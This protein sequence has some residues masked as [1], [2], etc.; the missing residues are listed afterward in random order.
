MESSI[1]QIEEASGPVD[2]PRGTVDCELHRVVGN[3]FKEKIEGFLDGG[4]PLA[5]IMLEARQFVFDR[6]C[7]VLWE[8]MAECGLTAENMHVNMCDPWLAERIRD[9]ILFE[10]GIHEALTIFRLYA[11]KDGGGFDVDWFLKEEKRFEM[12]I[13]AYFNVG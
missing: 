8:H 6:V 9:R 11:K 13:D 7:S 1:N 3:K 12:Q 5:E 4:G 2:A 10:G